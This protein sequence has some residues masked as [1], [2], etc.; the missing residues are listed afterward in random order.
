MRGRVMAVYT[1]VFFGFM[2]VGSL[3]IGGLAQRVGPPNAIIASA[4]VCAV[5]AVFVWS[6][7]QI[8]S[9]E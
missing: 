1:L 4:A 6:S 8:R 2:P 3:W 5:V 9:L 7:S